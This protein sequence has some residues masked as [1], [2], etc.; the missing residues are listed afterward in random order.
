MNQKTTIDQIADR[1][2]Q[3]T[4]SMSHG[5]ACFAACRE[6]GIEESELPNIG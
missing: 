5:Q 6:M 1:A 2:N 3:L 4:G